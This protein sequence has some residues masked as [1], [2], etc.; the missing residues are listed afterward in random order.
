MESKEE[1]ETAVLVKNME[2]KKAILDYGYR[3]LAGKGYG[4]I[5]RL[6]NTKTEINFIVNNSTIAYEL[7]KHFEEGKQ[8]NKEL[9]NI[10][11]QLTMIP[12]GSNSDSSYDTTN[13]INNKNKSKEKGQH[14]M[15]A[16]FKASIQKDEEYRNLPY[17]I[18]HTKEVGDKAGVISMDSPYGREIEIQR[19][20]EK[21]SRK[22]D[23]S[24]TQ[25][26]SVLPKYS[27]NKSD[28]LDLTPFGNIEDSRFRGE[29]KKKWISKGGFQ[30]YG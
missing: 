17:F 12:K 6:K 15:S 14:K 7:M 11:V 23:I 29:N 18:R 30:I 24:N 19:L 28:G 3:F 22:K 16:A 8:L 26:T 10:E 2:S 21:E 20:E 9:K 4:K 1:F 5:Y 13:A 25:F 27:Y